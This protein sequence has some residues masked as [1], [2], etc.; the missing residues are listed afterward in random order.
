MEPTLQKLIAIGG[1]IEQARERFGKGR[2]R[3]GQTSLQIAMDILKPEIERLRKMVN[4]KEK[5]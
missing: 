1:R 3:D 4:G 5:G 2:M